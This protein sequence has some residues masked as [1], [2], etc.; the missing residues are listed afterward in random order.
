M[1]KIETNFPILKFG[2]LVLKMLLLI[3]GEGV[4]FLAWFSFSLVVSVGS[5]YMRYD[6]T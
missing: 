6:G 4:I 1:V 2:T 5:K 3:W